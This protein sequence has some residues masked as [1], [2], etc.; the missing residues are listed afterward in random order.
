MFGTV[1]DSLLL[2]LLVWIAWDIPAR[3]AMLVRLFA[4]VGPPRAP[5]AAAAVPPARDAAATRGGATAA[6]ADVEAMVSAGGGGHTL[7]E[8][9]LSL[10]DIVKLDWMSESDPFVRPAAARTGVCL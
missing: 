5:A 6:D 4:S 7:V 10:R 9:Y 3:R 1:V 8:L 2:C